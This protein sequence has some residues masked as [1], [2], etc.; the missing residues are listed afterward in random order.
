VIALALA[1]APGAA[2][3]QSELLSAEEAAALGIKESNATFPSSHEALLDPPG[4]YPADYNWCDID[5][6]RH[7]TPS[8]NQHIPQ[9]CGSCWAH[10]A[11]SAL[12]DRIKIA[13]KGQGPDVMLSVQHIL[14]CGHAG[15]CF[16]GTVGGA[17]NWMKSISDKTGSGVAYMSSDPYLAC[18]G[19]FYAGVC[20]DRRKGCH[21]AT[22]CS[23]D[24]C[25][26]LERYPNATIGDHGLIAG[27]DGMMKEI[28]N[29][30]PIACKVD[31]AT[32]I[33]Y[34]GGVAKGKSWRTDHVIEVTGWGTDATEGEYWV[35]RNSWGEFWGENGF[36][37]VGFGSLM[38]DSKTPLLAG[39]SWAVPKDFT[40]PERHNDAPCTMDGTCVD[41]PKEAAPVSPPAKHQSA[42]LSKVEVEARGFK[43]RGNSSE[44]SSHDSL[45]LQ[46][47]PTDFTWCNKD[48]ID[49]CTISLNQHIPQYCGSCWAHG[50]L[51]A[52]ADR[53]KIARNA[54]GI[55][56]Q[57]S[58][59]HLLNCGTAGSCHGGDSGS[60]YQWLKKIGDET[61][62]GIGYTTA[63]PYLACSKD[64]TNG[65]CKDLD[66]TCT[67][68]NVARTCP[69]FG[70]A[71]VG[72]DN[73]PNATI[74]EHGAITG[75]DA[76]KKELFS[77]GPIE[78]DIDAGP[79][80]S[81]T[82]G[83]VTAKGAGTDHA[84]S[85]VGWGTDAKLGL[86]WIVRNSWGEYWGEHGFVRVQ[87]GALSIGSA[88][89]WATPKDFTAPE[90]GNQFHCFEDGSNCKK[91]ED[92]LVV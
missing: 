49:F 48:G 64:S 18:S 65:Y 61:G 66:W 37:R 36:V 46:A 12:N 27:K 9:Y 74:A 87:E 14:D 4:G 58:V 44:Q 63:Q 22:T 54:S 75:T 42:L 24:N 17:Y 57:L 8:L 80:E 7:C 35:V 16:G 89:T 91:A 41:K 15:S 79:I 85:V 28:F 47:Y 88:C 43:W 10:G 60:A 52:L 30:G 26:D 92:T 84:I 70:E 86:Y 11:V 3:R 2:A 5:G 51:S 90:R 50:A 40:A 32:L 78:C 69:T 82:G 45:L 53:I 6:G 25:K 38:I 77:R 23:G 34:T 68:L 62:A 83:I 76:M 39:C 72:L 55:E 59:Q 71:C 81:Y 20:K 67:P 33:K 31:A 13:R 21:P 29:R 73:Y 56:I 19:N 1:L